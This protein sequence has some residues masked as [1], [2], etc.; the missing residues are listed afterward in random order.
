VA[1][2]LGRWLRSGAGLERLAALHIPRNLAISGNATP[3]SQRGGQWC[4]A[5]PSLSCINWHAVGYGSVLCYVRGTQKDVGIADS[6]CR[7]KFRLVIYDI[8][9]YFEPCFTS[10]ASRTGKVT[11]VVCEQFWTRWAVH[12]PVSLRFSGLSSHA[13]RQVQTHRG[14]RA[15]ILATPVAR[16]R[17]HQ[18]GSHQREYSA[19]SRGSWWWRWWTRVPA[20]A[21]C[22]GA[23]E[24]TVFC[25]LCMHLLV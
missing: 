23:A 24:R 14:V 5:A 1:E 13:R 17:V 7:M 20:A 25:C 11:P 2:A 19:P 10:P 18:H 12:C 22:L 6:V 16:Q 8:P 9:F 21:H 15:A 4:V 3:K